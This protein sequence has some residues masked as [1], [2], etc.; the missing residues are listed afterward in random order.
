MKE[1]T[2][3][4]DPIPITS[5][6]L[7]VT[8]DY[9]DQPAYMLNYNLEITWFNDAS[10]SWLGDISR[11]PDDSHGRHI[12]QFIANGVFGHNLDNQNEF[13][14]IHHEAGAERLGKKTDRSRGKKSSRKA[15]IN[16]FT[17]SLKNE[18]SISED[19]Q[20]YVSYYREGMLFIYVPE[21]EYEGT[22][23][24]LIQVLGHR[25]QVVR[26]LLKKHL[27]VLT[28]MSVLVADLQN[29]RNLCMQLPPEE[30]FELINQMWNM[31]EPIFR[32][33]YGTHGKHVSDG[34]VYF[35]LPQ[36]DCSYLYNAILCA[37]ELR[38]EMR[39]LN[40]EWKLRKNWN[41]ELRLK[42]GLHAGKEWLGTFNAESKVEFNV[43]GNTISEAARLS[44]FA[45]GSTIWASKTL[46]SMLDPEHRNQI[47]YGI[48]TQDDQ[49]V[50]TLVE[51]TFASPSSVLPVAEI[52]E[53]KK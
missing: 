18:D 14:R 52:I 1:K 15:P 6:S 9:I 53:I 26:D 37:D 16:Q 23:E 19:Y 3:M 45:S 5:R 32:K 41:V 38:N 47:R 8:V 40:Q 12:V 17:M 49:G 2:T 50:E 28:E 21:S 44:E 46:I 7:K 11:L 42:I 35:F 48:R 20:V 13:N 29:S 27:P 33:F 51:S 24:T 39:K 43:L 4:V 36:P 22:R 10:S 31:V 34:M 30:Y 25:D